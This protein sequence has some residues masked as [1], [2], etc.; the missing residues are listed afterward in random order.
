M[1]E[2]L[3]EIPADAFSETALQKATIPHSVTVIGDGAFDGCKYMTSVRMSNQVEVIGKDAFRETAVSQVAFPSTLK[4]IGQRAFYGCKKLTVAELPEGLLSIGKQAFAEGNLRTLKVP[5]TV[6]K[7]GSK[8]FQVSYTSG[9]FNV[10][11]LCDQAELGSD[12]F[13]DDA[14]YAEADGGDNNLKIILT[15]R[16][17]G[18]AD[19]KYQNEVAVRKKYMPK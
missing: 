11:M 15:C 6:E 2:G 10:T 1:P 8:A 9:G 18:A 12:L 3:T 13:G 17:G 7:I 5:S 4:E 16:E 14:I 19:Q